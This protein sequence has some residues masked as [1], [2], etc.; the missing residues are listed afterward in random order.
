MCE[1]YRDAV[2]LLKYEAGNFSSTVKCFRNAISIEPLCYCGNDAETQRKRE[3]KERNNR[4]KDNQYTGSGQ[5]N[6]NT[7]HYSAIFYN[8]VAKPLEVLF[9]TCESDSF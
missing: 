6:R 8:S 1:Y 2:N 4:I 7:R 5:K 9:L 3:I